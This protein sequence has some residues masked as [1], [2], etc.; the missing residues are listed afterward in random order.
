M[1]TLF[2]LIS[3]KARKNY[4]IYYMYN[5]QGT[6]AFKHISSETFQTFLAITKL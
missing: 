1:F 4:T 6:E 2:R 5:T 3:S